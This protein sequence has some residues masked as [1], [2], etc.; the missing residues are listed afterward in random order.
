MRPS[1]D[2]IEA[3]RNA[4]YATVGRYLLIQGGIS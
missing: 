3:R 1:G 2:M 4:A